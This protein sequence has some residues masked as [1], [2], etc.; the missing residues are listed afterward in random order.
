[1]ANPHLES[2]ARRLANAAIDSQLVLFIGAGVSVGAGLPTWAELLH[3]VALAGGIEPEI[4]D[5]LKDKDYRDQATLLER[6]LDSEG[7]GL[8][9]SVSSQLATAQRY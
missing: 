5:L 2:C 3:K 8:K 7:C 4:I 6:W 9:K 1:E